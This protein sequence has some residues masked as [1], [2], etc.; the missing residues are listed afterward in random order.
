MD[1]TAQTAAMC[2]VNDIILKFGFPSRVTSDNGPAF[3]SQLFKELNKRLKVKQITT[4]P[5]N[6]VER[7]NRIINAYL[8]AFIEKKPQQWASLLPYYMFCYNQT[9]HSTTQFS[10]HQLVFGFEITMPNQVLKK[11]PV[12][13]YDN[14]VEV[15]RRELCEAWE[16]AKERLTERKIYNKSQYDKKATKHNN[17][18]SGDFILIKNQNLKGKHDPIWLGPID[19]DWV[20]LICEDGRGV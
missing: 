18:Q 5:S 6:I 11:T 9:I 16:L 8:R 15:A 17:I 4:T 12:Y 19:V 2:F 10:P 13:N 3:I 1:C 7:Q 14:Y 20:F